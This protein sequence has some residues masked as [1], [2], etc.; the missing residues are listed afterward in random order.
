MESI[1]AVFF[2]IVKRKGSRI[3]SPFLMKINIFIEK[4]V[5]LKIDGFPEAT[6]R[7][8]CCILLQKEIIF[9]FL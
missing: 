7:G 2:T 6:N 1:A 9:S 4:T 5:Y 3:E 8:L